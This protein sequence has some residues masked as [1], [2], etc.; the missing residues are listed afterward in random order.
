M[1][2]EILYQVDTLR[3]SSYYLSVKNINIGHILL[4]YVFDQHYTKLQYEMDIKSK[5]KRLISV[6]KVDLY[7]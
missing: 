5:H 7:I 6:S 1:V 4:V 2:N 3:Y